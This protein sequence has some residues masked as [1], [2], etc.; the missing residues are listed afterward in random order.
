[1]SKF[2]G[3]GQEARDGLIALVEA[4][5]VLTPEIR[6]QVEYFASIATSP[7]EPNRTYEWFHDS[8]ML[9]DA[10][11]AHQPL[12]T[13][14]YTD[15][16]AQPD[17]GFAEASGL[18]IRWQKGILCPEAGEI[19]WNGSYLR[20]VLEAVNR[21]MS[22]LGSAKSHSGY[23]VAARLVKEAM[24]MLD[25]LARESFKRGEPEGV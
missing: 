2:I 24:S 19:P 15:E 17:G 7:G 18:A 1:M 8:A 10:K 12:L 21:R 23:D 14:D 16:Y 5:F 22:F 4:M 11:M 13:E 6:S 25:G 20:T 9:M 3:K